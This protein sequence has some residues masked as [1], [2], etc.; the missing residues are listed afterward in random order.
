M[1]TLRTWMIRLAGLFSKTQHEQELAAEI[2]S[3]LQMHMDDNVR[4]GM[5]PDEARREA[6]LKLGGVEPTKQ[7]YREG[8]TIPFSKACFKTLSFHCAN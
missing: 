8:T 3:H 6:I 1:K 2:E 5:K 7:A 4:A